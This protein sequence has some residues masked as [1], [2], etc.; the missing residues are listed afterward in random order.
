MQD[1]DATYLVRK[2]P[3]VSTTILI[4]QVQDRVIFI[5]LLIFLIVNGIIKVSDNCS[6]CF[7]LLDCIWEINFL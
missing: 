2:H 5:Y 1:Y 6:C 4:D 7:P 3:N